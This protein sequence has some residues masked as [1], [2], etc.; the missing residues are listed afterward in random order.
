MTSHMQVNN[1]WASGD[2]ERARHY[3]RRALGWNVAAIVT[4]SMLVVIGGIA[5]GIYFGVVHTY[6][7]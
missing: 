7:Y 1:S 3:A 5:A 6:Y 2:Y 4:G